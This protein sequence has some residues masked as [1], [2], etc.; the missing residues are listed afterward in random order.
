[1]KKS[2]M[3]QEEKN[4]HERAVKMKKMTDQQ[5]CNFIDRTYGKGMEEGQK[6]EKVEKKD[7]A[8]TTEIETFI[9]YLESRLGSGNH[10]G[11]GTIMQIRREIERYANDTGN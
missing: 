9:K 6:L 1:M 2:K 4:M 8:D 7:T 3:T 5:L 11:K 10:I